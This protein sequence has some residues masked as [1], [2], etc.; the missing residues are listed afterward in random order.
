MDHGYLSIAQARSIFVLATHRRLALEDFDNARARVKVSV[1]SV[2]VCWSIG[3][4]MLLPAGV[5]V[6][7]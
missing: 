1:N 2:V 4:P 5:T 3:L 7:A 6:R